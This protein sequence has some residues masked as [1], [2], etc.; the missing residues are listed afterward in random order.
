MSRDTP[1]NISGTTPAA[2]DPP[3]EH[4]RSQMEQLLSSPDFKATEAQRSFLVHVIEKTLAGRSNEIKGYT[5]ATEVFGRGENFDQATDP[6]VS[7]QANKLRR[8][9]ERYYLTA[10]RHDSIR[11]DI[12]KGTYVPVFIE[13]IQDK[14]AATLADGTLRS[15]HE[16]V[17]PAVKIAPLKN[18]TG[19][20]ANDHLGLGFSTE[21]AVE[22]SRFQEIRTVYEAGENT[23][24]DHTAEPRFTINGAVNKSNTDIKV[25]LY[26]TDTQTGRQIWSDAHHPDLSAEQ[27]IVFQEKV[28]RQVAVKIA[29][30]HGVISRNLSRESRQK[31]PAEL[32]TYEAILCYHEFD[33][34]WVPESMAKA[35]EALHHA[36]LKEPSCGQVW[37]LLG[38]LYSIIYALDVEGVET[39][40]DKAIEYASKGL[41]INPNNQRA[42]GTMALVHFFADE[43]PAAREEVNRALSL[44]PNSL[45]TVDGLGYIL[46]LLGDWETGTRLIRISIIN[47]PYYRNEVHYALWVNYL[48]QQD[49]ENAYM[50]TMKLRWHDVFWYPLVKASTLGLLGEIEEG[51]NYVD[52]LLELKPGFPSK[53]RDLIGR[54]IKFDEILSAVIDGLNKSGL[55]L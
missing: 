48:R 34:T 51:N 6:I 24:L 18:L 28:A 38:R 22:I 1:S 45:M 39:P 13:N 26:L 33:Q 25:S 32:S 23:D 19:D 37:T 21:L 46:T 17:W 15:P 30:D 36:A 14:S 44:N 47:N 40:L 54:Y 5:V 3:L 55:N 16:E 43:L 42:W 20:A 35:L 11:I 49:L 31:A 52:K 29:D 27:L 53:G 12:P 9:L 4:V 2:L 7:I 8:A 41:G 10:G 50:E